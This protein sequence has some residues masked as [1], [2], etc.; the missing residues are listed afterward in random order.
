MF[1]L[2]LHRIIIDTVKDNRFAYKKTCPETG[3]FA[4]SL[5]LN[6]YFPA[7]FFT[8]E[9]AGLA[10][11]LIGQPLCMRPKDCLYCQRKSDFCISI[12][13]IFDAVY[14]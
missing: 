6:V 10:G 11:R 3:L 12:D 5:Y 13:G 9:A 4:F 2:Q 8:N 14:D 1:L 7:A